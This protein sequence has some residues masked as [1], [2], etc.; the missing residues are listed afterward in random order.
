MASGGL[1]GTGPWHSLRLVPSSL[2]P[3]SWAWLLPLGAVSDGPSGGG[4]GGHSA[5]TLSLL[6]GQFWFG[7][8]S[9]SLQLGPAHL[10]GTCG[11]PPWALQQVEQ[12]LWKPVLTRCQ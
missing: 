12:Y 3:I 5:G 11:K 2:S 6:S 4:G 7:K 9:S 8:P 10:L 1:V